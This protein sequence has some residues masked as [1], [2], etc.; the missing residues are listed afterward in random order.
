MKLWL[1][2]VSVVVL[3]VAACG[4]A[5]PKT[6]A[7]ASGSPQVVPTGTASGARQASPSPV[8]ALPPC[9][10]MPAGS[11]SASGQSVILGRLS[12]STSWMVRD[13]T[14]IGNPATLASLGDKW[15][16]AN[17][18]SQLD[19]RLVDPSTLAWVDW[20]NQGNLVE[21]ASNGS[22]LKTLVPGKS[23]NSI[24]SFAWSPLGTQWTYLVNT[25]SALEW[26]LANGGTDRVLASLP[27]IPPHGGTP[28]LEPL[29]VTFSADGSLVAMTDSAMGGG[30]SG[31][32]AKMQIRRADGSL[33]ATPAAA[34]SDLLWVGSSLFFRDDTGIDVW[35]QSGV[36][37]VL[38]GV[39]WIRPKL[40]PDGRL[41]V[42]HTEDANQLHHVFVYDLTTQKVRQVSPAGGSEAWFLGSRYVWFLEER[43][44]APNESCGVSNARPTGKTYIIDL[45]SGTATQSRITRI[46]DTWPRPGAPNFENIWWMDASAWH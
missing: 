26:H 44:C 46:A 41:I 32:Q 19:A 24:I 6:G 16:W 43:L 7:P 4:S 3:L 25:P 30:G 38:P 18:T 37:S 28:R 5:A 35:N 20:N 10:A 29:M 23:G 9:G 22:G 39:Q 12:G 1:A 17:A 21:S 15:P 27:S 11:P 36:C 45:V 14:D 13:V 33:V 31:D 2:A 42:F 8:A 40:S 34:G